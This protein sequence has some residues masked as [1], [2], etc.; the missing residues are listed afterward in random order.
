MILNMKNINILILALNVLISVGVIF[1]ATREIRKFSQRGEG[2]NLLKFRQFLNEKARGFKFDLSMTAM[3]VGM[4]AD[5]AFNVI[6]KLEHDGT[7][8]KGYEFEC[9]TCHAKKEIN[10]SHLLD[11][12]IVCQACSAA[13]DTP[14]IKLHYMKL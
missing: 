14:K 2:K 9:P 5:D 8:A 12:M 4:S 13:T 11:S 7:V 10:L 6:P 1:F 3:Q